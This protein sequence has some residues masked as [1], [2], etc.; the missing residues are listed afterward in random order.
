MEMSLTWHDIDWIA[1]EWDGPLALKGIVA[2]ADAR[3]AVGAGAA[4][5]VI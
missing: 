2:A 1:Q 4:A 5:I 3:A